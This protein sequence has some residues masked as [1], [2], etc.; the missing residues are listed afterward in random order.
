MQTYDP[1]TIQPEGRESEIS[2]EEISVPNQSCEG[3]GK[4]QREARKEARLIPDLSEKN[5]TN[6]YRKISPTAN[7]QGCLEWLGASHKDGYGRFGI[8]GRLFQST[9]IAF[10]VA[11]GIDPLNMDVCHKC[12]NPPCCNPDHL[13]LGTRADNVKDMISKGRANFQKD[14]AKP[15]SPRVRPAYIRKDSA[16]GARHG[17]CKLDDATVTMIREMYCKSKTTHAQIAAEFGVVQSLI[18]KIIRRELWRHV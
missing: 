17:Q 3:A 10:F 6:F 18:G 12:D 15:A 9:R 7:D 2:R 16:V 8:A 4:A 11:T 1:S 5:I 13:F 14:P